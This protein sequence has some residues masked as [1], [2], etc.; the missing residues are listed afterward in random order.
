[1][2]AKGILKGDFGRGK[3]LVSER[4][5][6][7]KSRRGSWVTDVQIRRGFSGDLILNSYIYIPPRIERI[8]AVP[9]RVL[10]HGALLGAL[11]SGL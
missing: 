10:Q 1:M 8:E 9:S 2:A 5:N 7:R 3:E 11:V 4:L 6:C